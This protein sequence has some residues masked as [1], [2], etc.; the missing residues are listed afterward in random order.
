MRIIKLTVTQSK[1]VIKISNICTGNRHIIKNDYSNFLI[2]LS[3][4]S[5][6][7]DEQNKVPYVSELKLSVKTEAARG[8]VFGEFYKH[9]ISLNSFLL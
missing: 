4:I 5:I 3:F 8:T 7:S 2:T 9:Y 6:I 1:A